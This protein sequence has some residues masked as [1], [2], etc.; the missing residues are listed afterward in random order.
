[1]I[2]QDIE[3]VRPPLEMP[4]LPVAR[5]MWKPAPNLL[6]GLKCWMLCGGAHHSVLTTQVD[7][8]MMED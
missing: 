2:V 1:M 4:N 3:C 8:A 5:V 6:T 7:A